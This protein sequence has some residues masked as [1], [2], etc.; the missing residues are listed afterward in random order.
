[1]REVKGFT[2]RLLK[3]WWLN[4]LGNLEFFQLISTSETQFG[5]KVAPLRRPAACQRSAGG[6]NNV[7]NTLKLLNWKSMLLFVKFKNLKYLNLK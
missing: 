5:H 1:M 4:P 3:G 6:P 7:Q 2:T